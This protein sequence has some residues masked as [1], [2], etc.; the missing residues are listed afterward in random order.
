M[1]NYVALV[2]FLIEPLLEDK[3][4]LKV[5]CESTP[6][7]TWLRVA[8]SP[9]DKG[10]VFG[11]GGRTIQAIRQMVVTAAKLTDRHA[12]IEIYEPESE[13]T[14][15]ENSEFNSDYSPTS[16]RLDRPSHVSQP[17]SRLVTRDRRDINSENS[18]PESENE[19]LEIKPERPKPE[20]PQK[21]IKKG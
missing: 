5:D 11:K 18:T 4:D 7:R 6:N 12:S 16:D 9:K 19:P 13:K 17:V 8:F 14:S 15:T 20:K 21:S 10:R 2:Q 3:T 1:V